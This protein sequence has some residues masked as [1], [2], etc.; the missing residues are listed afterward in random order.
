M[1]KVLVLQHH[2]AENLGIIADAL[3][4]AA[5]AW[6]YVRVFDGHRVPDSMKGAGGVVVMG[7]PM[8]V[9]EQD[10]YGFLRE[11]IA[12]IKAALGE[13]KPVLGVCLGSQ[14]LAAA[15]GAKV[16]P[17]PEKE[18][19]WYPVRLAPAAAG[20]AL[21]GGLPPSFTACHW[22]GDVFEVPLGATALASSEKTACQA[23]RYGKIA[24]GLLFHLEFTA[25]TIE[26]LVREEGDELLSAG[27]DGAEILRATMSHGP[28]ANRIGL[29]V[30]G[31][32]AAMVRPG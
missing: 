26:A 7:G 22:H 19:G 5:L 6:Q 13:G 21:F 20:D 15:L 10:R 25:A 27:V 12:L 4:S 9:Y 29:D 24:W 1:A 2:P 16:S 32:W 31:R 18:I 14:L 3:A 23:F 17:G 28:E 11:E 8:G 30:F